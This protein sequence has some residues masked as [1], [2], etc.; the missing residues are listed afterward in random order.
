MNLSLQYVLL[1]KEVRVVFCDI[2]QAFDRVLHPGH[3]HKLKASGVSGTLLDWLEN[4]LSERRQRVVLPG[5]ISDWVYIKA[6][7][8]QGSI[9]GPLLS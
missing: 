8:P 1:C 7:V 9:L 2:S 3:L 4:Y 5:S 6:G